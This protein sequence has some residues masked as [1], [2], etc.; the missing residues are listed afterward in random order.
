MKRFMGMMPSKDVDKEQ[1]FKVGTL[2]LKV[3]IQSGSKGWTILYADG[4]SEYEDVEDTVE[5]N[6]NK[7]FTILNKRFSD[8]NLI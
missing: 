7:A 1:N 5:N 2:K 6:Y 3:T 4:S 8:I